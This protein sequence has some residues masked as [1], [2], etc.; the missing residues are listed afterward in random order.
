MRSTIVAATA[1]AL[2]ACSQDGTSTSEM[3]AAA[4]QRA[5]QALNLPAEVALK[6]TVWIGHEE[7]VGASV[8]CG[9][10]AGSGEGAP[11]R[12]QRFAATG[13]P[14]EWLVFEDAHDPMIATRSEKLPDWA[15]YCGKSQDM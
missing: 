14:I 15:R 3:R 4:E 11:V 7:Y 9:T 6:S 10:V 8:M 2:A 5:R 1:L 12:P 13:D